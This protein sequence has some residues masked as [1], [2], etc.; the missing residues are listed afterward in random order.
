MEP[1][2]SEAELVSRINNVLNPQEEAPEEVEAPETEVTA[3]APQEEAPPQEEAAEPEEQAIDPDAPFIPLKTKVEGGGDQEETLSINQLKAGYMMQKDYHRKT[4]EL[5]KARDTL[6][7]EV[8]QGISS[9]RQEY[10][11]GLRVAEQALISLIVPELQGVDMEKLA[12]ENPS[13]AVLLQAR[14]GKLHQSVQW[15]RQQRAQAEQ[16]AAKT[17]SEQMERALADPISGVPG[18]GAAMKEQLASDAKAYGFT[19]EEVSA[20]VDPRM[21]RVLHDAAQ[22]QKAKSAKPKE[23]VRPTPKVLK[24]GV[25]QGSRELQAK[26][27]E[28]LMANFK[29]SGSIDDGAALL[30]ARMNRK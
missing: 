9:A 12:Y 21:F 15:I 27:E 14:A 6:T 2:A 11:E 18:W 25:Q 23:Q 26:N 19:P 3:E 10:L 16:Q 29:K 17:L 8:E 30:L 4:Q 28:K 5:A 22:F 24:P 7:K 13:Q 1:E 20:V